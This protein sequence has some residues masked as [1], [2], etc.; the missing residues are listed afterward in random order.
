MIEC[1]FFERSV[2]VNTKNPDKSAFRVIRDLYDIKRPFIYFD[3]ESIYPEK[4]LHPEKTWVTFR[5][6]GSRLC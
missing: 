4:G 3:L 5:G 1:T 6:K 2:W